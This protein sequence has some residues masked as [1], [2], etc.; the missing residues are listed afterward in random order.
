MDQRSKSHQVIL[1]CAA[2][3]V[4]TLAT[5]WPV[6]H[7]DFVN[8]DDPDYVTENKWV[9]SGLTW[10]SVEWAFTAGHS[11]NWHP[12]T[13]LSHMVDV[14]LFGMKP[15]GHHITSLLFHIA[16]S[17][18]L[19]LLLRQMTGSVWRSAMVA[20]LFALHP[21]HV[22]SVAWIAERKDVLSTFFGLLALMA[23]TKYAKSKVEGRRSKA[24]YALTLTFLALG[25]MSKPMLV[26]WPFVMLLLDFWPL[27]R[28]SP[29]TFDLRPSTLKPLILEKIPFFLMVAISCGITLVVQQG[30]MSSATVSILDRFGNATLGYA[31]YLKQTFW[32]SNLAVF[33]PYP[34]SLSTLLALIA[35]A[36][37][38]VISFL[39][40]RHRSNQPALFTGWFWYLGTLVP[41]IGWVQVGSQA[42]ADRYTYVP[43]IGIFIMLAWGIFA[44]LSRNLR[45]GNL[46]VAGAVLGVAACAVVTRAQVRNW[47]NSE[48]LFTH[49]ARVTK[50]N[51]IA[52]AGLGT[53]NYKRDQ[54]DEAIRNLT[55]A[56]E[57]SPPGKATDLFKYYLGATLQKSGRG[58]DAL[59]YL[60]EAQ[61]V[62]DLAPE[63]DYRLGLSLLE[64]GRVNEAETAL[65]NACAAKPDN[66]EFQ[67]GIAALL[68][69]QKRATEAEQ[70]LVGIV[71]KHPDMWLAHQTFAELLMGQ[72]KSSQAET[73]Y[74]KAV[75]LSPTDP[76]LR[77]AYAACLVR[78]GKSDQA[79]R[80]LEEALKLRPQ[81]AQVWF[82]LAEV[83]SVTGHSRRAVELYEQV[84]R[85]S[86]NHLPALNNL[87]WLLATHPDDSIRDG[88]RAVDLAQKAC[89]LTEWK[90]A[91]LIGTLAAAYAEAG[92]F[93]K[94]VSN[95]EQA[96]SRAREEN[97]TEVA[98]RNEEL[99][100]LYQS[101]KP[102]REK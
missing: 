2:L 29:S 75:S 14:S 16:N 59:P 49:A 68:I 24:A 66:A 21:L 61:N 6:V 52:L 34:S 101:G 18:L 47:S 7:H 44:L 27:K 99:L 17:L 73:H 62:G 43:L 77:R 78:L 1:L 4:V 46:F 90:Q 95:A 9:N 97:Q 31:A 12:M 38:V 50:G 23:Y 67:L 55:Q 42:R 91:V 82:E 93:P 70:V 80:E 3:I 8:Y 83:S 56:L 15:G 53:V 28:I 81:D 65:K 48:T 30:A 64:A 86:P 19:L 51:Y 39:V 63:R 60:E 76:K 32:P 13:W 71:S 72:G 25:L 69:Q 11:S 74:A 37:L 35:A 36:I 96:C 20:A 89:E 26:T 92:E 58:R 79:R 33:Y 98:K 102:F 87:A 54:F 100:K 57:Y 22:E 88:K 94:A 85:A 41:V 10:S 45:L 84:I 40:F 5:F